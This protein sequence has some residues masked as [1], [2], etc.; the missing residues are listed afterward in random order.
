LAAGKADAGLGSEATASAFGRNF[1]PL[2]EEDYFLV[3]LKPALDLPAVEALRQV[4]ASTAW[5]QALATL[6]G[7]AVQRP[8]EVLSLARALP[9]WHFRGQRQAARQ[10]LRVAV[11]TPPRSRTAQTPGDGL[12]GHGGQ[13]PAEPGRPPRGPADTGSDL[14]RRSAGRCGA[15]AALCRRHRSMGASRN[16]WGRGG[17]GA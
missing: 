1:W 3:Y 11:L 12:G 10:A 6:P 9:W 17:V 2:A 4:L 15:D 14:V 8:G 16:A 7:S 13:P 5:L